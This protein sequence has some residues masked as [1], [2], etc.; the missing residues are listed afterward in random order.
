MDTSVLAQQPARLLQHLIRFD[1]RNPPG[2][3]RECI[4]YIR[5]LL[6]DAGIATTILARHPERP[7]LL[8][9]L[10]GRGEAAPLLMQGHIDVVPTQNQYWQHSP[11]NGDIIDGEVWGRGAVDMKGGVAMML[12]ACLRAQADPHSLSGDVVLALVADEETGGEYGA[13]YLVEEHSTYFS[14]IRY[15]IGESGGSPFYIGEKK[16]VPIQVQEKQVCWLKVTLSGVGGHASTPCRDSVIM[17]LEKFLQCI[18]EKR[19]PVHI[20]ATPQRMIE[21]LIHV[22]P[23]QGGM[24]FQRLLDAKQTDM[25]LDQMGIYGLWLDA[26]LHNTVNV[27]TIHAGKSINVLPT[28]VIIQLDGRL[29]PGYSPVDLCDEL[30]QLVG[31]DAE[32]EIVRHDRNDVDVD[33]GLFECLAAALHSVDPDSIPIPALQTATSDAR[34]FARLGIQSYGFLPTN[35]PA[36]YDLLH[37]VHAENE[38]IPVASVEFGTRVLHELLKRQR[39]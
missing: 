1:T 23:E 34:F 30:H 24:Y 31:E 25:V 12:A 21:A 36:G 5:D 3:E 17:Q 16:L 28:E 29:L 27:T 7:N 37:G 35:I 22:L 20:T 15:A 9:R 4:C 11:F 39:I 10:R 2:N 38:R 33:L 26:A 19:L 8:A 18:R 13:Q 6:E 14:D 32:I